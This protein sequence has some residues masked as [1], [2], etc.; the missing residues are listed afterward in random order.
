MSRVMTSRLPCRQMEQFS[1]L[2]KAEALNRLMRGDDL[3]SLSETRISPVSN[4]CNCLTATL[5][6]AAPHRVLLSVRT[7]IYDMLLLFAVIYLSEVRIFHSLPNLSRRE[8]VLG[9]AEEERGEQS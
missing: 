6:T 9:T 5:I 7:E 2:I 4:D 8:D 3:T 1:A